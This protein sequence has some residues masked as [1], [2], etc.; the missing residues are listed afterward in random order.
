MTA[1]DASSLWCCIPDNAFTVSKAHAEC[2]TDTNT[3]GNRKL[4]RHVL[5]IDK[6]TQMYTLRLKSYL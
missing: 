6:S 1:T 4:S 5:S 3:R 2:I